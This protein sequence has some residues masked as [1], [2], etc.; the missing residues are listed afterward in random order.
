MTELGLTLTV[1]LP[2]VS[3]IFGFIIGVKIK[4]DHLSKVYKAGMNTGLEIA[5]ELI[6][7]T[8][9]EQE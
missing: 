3:F 4:E 1:G 5:R 2:I 6:L 7:N 9:G 8:K